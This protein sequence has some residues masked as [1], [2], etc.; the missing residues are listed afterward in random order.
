[1]TTGDVKK[2]LVQVVTEIVERH[3]MA[4]AAVTDEVQKKEKSI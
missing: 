4:R 2:R 3:R 1:M